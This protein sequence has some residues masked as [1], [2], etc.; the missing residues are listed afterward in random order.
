MDDREYTPREATAIVLAAARKRLE[1][2][3]AELQKAEAVGKSVHGLPTTTP[4]T[5]AISDGDPNGKPKQGR[6]VFKMLAAK[7]AESMAKS[8]APLQMS[9]KDDA[10]P[11]KECGKPRGAIA[12]KHAHL[13]LCVPCIGKAHK[14]MFDKYGTTN[15][16]G[17]RSIKSWDTKKGEVFVSTENGADPKKRYVEKGKEGVVPGDKAEKTV[18]AKGSGGDLE[19]AGEPLAAGAPPKPPKADKGPALKPAGVPGAEAG[20]A[21]SI[22]KP[23]AAP[24]AKG[25]TLKNDKCGIFG[26]LQKKGS[27]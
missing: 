7:K 23:P 3:L 1:A 18:E 2:G 9:E 22:P 6:T 5:K 4:S 13:G 16:D 17:S 14:E 19:K 27:K 26:R 21:P 12:P 20:K 25:M 10:K 24:G 11:C 15:P 8:G